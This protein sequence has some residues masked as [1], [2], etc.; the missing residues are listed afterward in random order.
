[1]KNNYV[2]ALLASLDEGMQIDTALSGLAATLKKNQHEK[3]LPSV[4]LEVLRVLEANKGELVA[5]VRVAKASDLQTLK[6]RIEATLQNLG[7]TRDTT[8]NE[9]VDETIV[10][11]YVATYN[12]QEEDRSHKKVLKSL[13]ESITK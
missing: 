10:G 9:I 5:E 8:V 12:F 2:Q 13:Y 6:S 11:G 3:L 4:L 7:V 1:M